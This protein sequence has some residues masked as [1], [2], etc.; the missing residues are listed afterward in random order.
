MFGLK[1]R[2]DD[3][4]LLLPKEFLVTEI[5][6]KYSGILKE[7]L[8][9]FDSPIDFLNETIQK[10]NVLGFQEGTIT[11]DQPVIGAEP[12]FKQN[13]IK[14][15]QFQYAGSQFN[16]RSGVP[17]IQLT[18]K[19]F[20]ITFR[21]T[22]GY[23]NYFMLFENFW[24]Q[25]SRDMNYEDLPQRFTIDIYNELG[26][27]YSRVSLFY[28]MINSMDMLEFDYTQPI[29]QSQTFNIE[30]KYS[31]FDFEF[32]SIDELSNEFDNKFKDQLN[33]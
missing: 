22:L 25:F 14:Q 2:Q 27:I 10:V 11:Q 6:E 33:S 30:F 9:Y 18:D 21:H 4:R 17:P 1:G 31:N 16:Y 26:S 32:I 29:A 23:L 13:R 3:F 28:P 20:N 8:G 19:T 24:Y 15:N 12:T 5:E 7:K